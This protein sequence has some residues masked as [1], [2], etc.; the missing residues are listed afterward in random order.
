[1]NV[2]KNKIESLGFDTKKSSDIISWI[3]K[4]VYLDQIETYLINKIEEIEDIYHQCTSKCLSDDDY[5]MF[6]EFIVDT[7][8]EM[9]IK[10]LIVDYSEEDLEKLLIKS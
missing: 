6:K 1:M 5:H 8:F 9:R 2:L 10:C 4:F 3:S 7:L